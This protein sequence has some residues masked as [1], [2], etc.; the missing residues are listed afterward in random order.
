[1]ATGPLKSAGLV[2][3][4]E[5][6]DFL[7]SSI[8]IACGRFQIFHNEHLR[9]VMAAWEK[10][11]HLIVG[12]TSPDPETAPVEAEDTNRSEEAANPCTYYERFKMIEGVLLEQG[13]SRDDFDIV[14]YP[15]GKPELIKYYVP[16]G[17]TH[18]VTI[19]DRWGH[20]KN[21]RLREMGYDVE[22]LWD[23]KPKGISSTMLREKIAAGQDW[24][25]YVPA[26]TYRF[27]TE[28]D[29]HKRI[30]EMMK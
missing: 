23:D 10:C 3:C 28:N 21:S 26:A 14:P 6:K 8:G 2:V 17:A 9:Y 20:R 25:Q 4:L 1:M 7:M 18:Y 22:V 19:L 29:I 13:L 15:I 12:I 16:K 11:D 30:A 24:S 5:R 27:I